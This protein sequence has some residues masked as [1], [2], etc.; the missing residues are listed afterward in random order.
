[1]TTLARVKIGTISFDRMTTEEILKLLLDQ[2]KSGKECIQ[3]MGGNSNHVFIASKNHYYAKICNES[4]IFFVDGQS[5]VIAAEFAGVRIPERIAGPDLMMKI[6][7]ECARN[8]L[9][10]FLLGGS[11]TSLANL[12]SNIKGLFPKVIAGA[13]SPP[14]GQWDQN[15]NQK[16][17]T[18][19]NTSSADL[20]MVGIS[21]PKQ[22][23]WVYE[24]KEKLKTKVAIGFGAAFD[25]HS[26]RVKRAPL[27]MQRI[28]LEWFHRFLQEPRRMWRRY[29]YANSYLGLLILKILILRVLQIGPI[30]S[31]NK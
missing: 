11:E 6:L 2:M 21:A 24:Q 19:I 14:F 7:S 30:G 5:I 12:Q 18:K 4:S 20:L 3:I 17:L 13:Y 23:I 15:E 29:L 1:M 10:V 8:K 28:C 25:F 27:W 16:I 26:G 31:K 9:K 22:D